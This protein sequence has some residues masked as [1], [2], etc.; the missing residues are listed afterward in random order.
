[1]DYTPPWKPDRLLAS[2]EIP[3][4]VLNQTVHYHIHKCPPPVPVLIQINPIS[5]PPHPMSWWSILILSSLLC[6]AYFMP[7]SC[8]NPILFHLVT[9]QCALLQYHHFT[10]DIQTRQYRCLEVLLGAGYGMP[11]DIW[12]TACM[13]SVTPWKITTWKEWVFIDTWKVIHVEHILTLTVHVCIS[14]SET[15]VRTLLLSLLCS[16]R[17][18]WIKPATI[19]ALISGCH[20]VLYHKKW[21]KEEQHKFCT[22]LG[23]W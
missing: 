14:T 23:L 1:M 18:L 21:T 12:S 17:V 4:I 8:E 20:F 11:A 6:L 7:N 16:Y 22:L 10:E 2:Q 13:V 5:T 15:Y 3:H 19:F 9:D